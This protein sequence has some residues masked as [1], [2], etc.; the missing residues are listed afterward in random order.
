MSWNATMHKSILERYSRNSQGQVVI[1]IAAGTVEDIYSHFDRY[2]PYVK[3][4]LS[5]DFADY[6]VTAA[7][8]IGNESFII[9][10]HFNEAP[11]AEIRSRITHSVHNYFMYLRELE[12]RELMRIIRRSLLMLFLGILILSVALWFSQLIATNT[13]VVK[14]VFAEGLTIAA[15]VALWEALSTFIINWAPYK[16]QIRLY[17]RIAQAPVSFKD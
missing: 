13:T 15:W 12:L 8:E 2:I 16:R 7:E 10:F 5:E 6:L 9:H 14:R 11:D 4:D 1:E 3:K 17:Q